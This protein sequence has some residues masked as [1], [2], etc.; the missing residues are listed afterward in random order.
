MHFFSDAVPL[1]ACFRKT[2]RMEP[3][4][5]SRKP[6]WEAS[7]GSTFTLPDAG[8]ATATVSKESPSDELCA[9]AGPFNYRQLRILLRDC[10]QV[11]RPV[12]TRGEAAALFCKS[13]RTIR[14]WIYKGQVPFHRWPSGESYFSPQDLEHILMIAV[15][16]TKEMR[17]AVVGAPAYFES[18]PV[19]RNPQDLKDHSCIGFRF[20]NG[21]YRWEFEKGRKAL[22]VNPQGPA[23]FDDPNLVMQACWMD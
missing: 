7:Q 13:A 3:R 10:G 20:R 1:N 9:E 2:T 23:S 5:N 14:N 12:F 6:R 22:T 19:P 18:N 16:V 4:K 11:F 15:R 21:L 8:S 17:L